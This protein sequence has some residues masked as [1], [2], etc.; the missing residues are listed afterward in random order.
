M[1][2]RVC[3]VDSRIDN[4]TRDSEIEMKKKTVEIKTVN[5][6]LWKVRSRL[7]EMAGESINKNATKNLEDL[8]KD[9]DKFKKDGTW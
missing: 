3:N 1:G 7:D 5:E 6:E 9:A 2:W 4:M 8:K